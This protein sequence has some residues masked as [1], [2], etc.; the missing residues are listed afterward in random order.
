MNPETQTGAL[1]CDENK[2]NPKK[3]RERTELRKPWSNIRYTRKRRKRNQNLAKSSQT[4]RRT[5]LEGK[6]WKSKA[7]DSGRN[8]SESR[9]REKQKEKSKTQSSSSTILILKREHCNYSARAKALLG[10]QIQELRLLFP[11]PLRDP[12]SVPASLPPATSSSSFELG[13]LSGWL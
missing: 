11:H 12:T 10:T 13:Y 6:F 1:S 7:L 5:H 2:Q 3:G 8:H 9:K 4:K